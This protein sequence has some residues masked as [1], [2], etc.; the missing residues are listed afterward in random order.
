MKP[1]A[2]EASWPLGLARRERKLDT[3]VI[4]QEFFLQ[5]SQTDMTVLLAL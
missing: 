4:V 1:C 3:I 5:S 2:A